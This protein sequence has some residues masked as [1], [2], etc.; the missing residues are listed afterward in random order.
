MIPFRDL[1]LDGLRY[2][3]EYATGDAS[4]IGP[5]G[6]RY[7]ARLEGPPRGRRRFVLVDDYKRYSPWRPPVDQPKLF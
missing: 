3:D 6:K 5:A 2:L 1:V 7:T 4:F